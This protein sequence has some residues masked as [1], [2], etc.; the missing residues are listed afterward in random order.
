MHQY[1][2]CIRHNDIQD[3]SFSNYFTISPTT[4]FLSLSSYYYP[5]FTKEKN[6]TLKNEGNK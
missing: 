6:E 5:K 3:S 4:T 2:N 1:I